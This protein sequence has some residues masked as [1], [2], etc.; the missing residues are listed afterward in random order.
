MMSIRSIIRRWLG[1]PTSEEVRQIAL[2]EIDAD[3]I[4]KF[5]AQGQSMEGQRLNRRIE[6][7]TAIL[8]HNREDTRG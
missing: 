2:R 5:P 8:F 3:H 4:W 7:D 6:R 1:V